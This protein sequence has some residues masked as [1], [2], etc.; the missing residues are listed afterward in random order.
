M[1]AFGALPRIG[2]SI[3]DRNA[4]LIVGGSIAKFTDEKE[5]T[6]RFSEAEFMS[7]PHASITTATIWTPRSKFDGPLLADVLMHVEAAGSRL[8]VQAL[9]NYSARI[10]MSDLR[11]YGPILAHSR[12]GKRMTARDLGPLF[13][14]YPRDKYPD[15]L[16]KLFAQARFIWQVR[17]I[18]VVE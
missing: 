6:Y 14:M 9:D 5:R 13:V 11:T 2:H 17:N 18:T 7:L 12:D 16:N 8:D 4:F 10:P 1:A 15:A 3:E